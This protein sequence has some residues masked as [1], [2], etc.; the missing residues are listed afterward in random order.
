MLEALVKEWEITDLV[1][2]RDPNAYARERD[3]EV[4]RRLE[5]KV[6]IHEEG[7]HHLFDPEE[8]V[9]NNKGKPTMTLHGW[10]TVSH[11]L[12]EDSAGGC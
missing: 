2:E 8:V 1:W 12:F 7:G 10:K 3:R 6:E 9:K 4:R 5:G 11:Q